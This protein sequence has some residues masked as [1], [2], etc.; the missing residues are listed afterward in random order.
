MASS[1]GPRRPP[2][3]APPAGRRETR[4]GAG[5]EFQVFLRCQPAHVADHEGLLRNV[6]GA[7]EVLALAVSE[8]F[9]PDPG[10]HHF[11]R[12]V[13]AAL[14]QQ[15][16]DA[17]TRREYLVAE[18]GIARSQFDHKAPQRGRVPRHIVRVLL[19][20]GVMGEHQR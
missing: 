1:E 4:H 17:F 7:A 5:Q 12:C 19:V 20:Q 10:R 3:N 14:E 2:G 18:V 13:H 9:Q 16:A 8:V 11:D 6:V 15:L